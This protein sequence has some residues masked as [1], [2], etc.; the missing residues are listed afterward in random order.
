MELP[1]VGVTPNAPDRSE[2]QLDQSVHQLPSCLVAFCRQASG[3]SKRA[4]DSTA[5]Y[6]PF[7]PGSLPGN[8]VVPLGSDGIDVMPDTAEVEFLA[9][10]FDFARH[11]QVILDVSVTEI[12]AMCS[13]GHPRAIAVPVEEVE[14]RRL[15]AE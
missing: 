14:G 3:D 2:S 5:Q 9:V 8:N 7:P 13:A 12:P 11:D 15:L 4:V 10:Q 6:V 1:I